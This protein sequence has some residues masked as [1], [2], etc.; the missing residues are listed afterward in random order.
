LS[1]WVKWGARGPWIGARAAWACYV[2]ILIPVLGTFQS[3]LQIA[4]DR[5]TYLACMGW[6][7]LAGA[8][9]TWIWGRAAGRPVRT[10]AMAGAFVIVVAVVLALAIRT[11]QQIRVWADSFQLW[12]HVASLY[13]DCRT[14]RLNLGTLFLGAHQPEQAKAQFERALENQPDDA[15]IHANLGQALSQLGQGEAAKTAFGRALDLN[16]TDDVALV[17]LGVLLAKQGKADEAAKYLQTAL[18]AAPNNALAHAHYGQLL[19]QQGKLEAAI[20]CYRTAVDLDPCEW[21]LRDRLGLALV[22]ARQ[23]AE[24]EATFR[25]GLAASTNDP[26]P[27]NAL[28]WFLATCPDARYHRPQEAVQLAEYA[29]QLTSHEVPAFLD[30][31]ATA[32]ARAS[33]FDLAVQTQKRAIELARAAGNSELANRCESRLALFEKQQPYASE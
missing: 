10:A 19:E 6:A 5:Y 22:A 3:G 24:A 33:R 30:T 13:P 28:A 15:E 23:Y 12:Q 14:A 31:L 27:A 4:A 21:S 7:V 17:G 2:I 29:C 9:L 16:P 8:G 11:R 26:R 1:L 18:E 32:Y 20:A 25:H